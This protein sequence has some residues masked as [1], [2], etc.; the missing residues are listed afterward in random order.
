MRDLNRRIRHAMSE[1]AARGRDARRVGASRLRGVLPVHRRASGALPDHPAVRV[2]RAG[3]ASLPLR[4]RLAGLRRGAARGRSRTA[5]SA[6]LD[7]EVTA[8]ALMGLGELVGMRWILWGDGELPPRVSHELERIIRCILE[9][10]T[11]VRRVGLVA[12]ASYLPERWMTAAEIAA[13]SGIPE[14]GDRREVRPAREAHRRR[15]TSTSATWRSRRSSGCSRRPDIDPAIDRRRH[16]LRLDVAGL[17]RCG[18]SRRASPTGSARQTR[19]RSSTTT[20]RTARRSRC[21]S[22]A[23]CCAP[24]RSCRTV[25]VV[26]ACRESYLLDYAQRALALHV[27]LRRRRGRRPARRRRGAR[28]SCSA[29]TRSRTARTRCR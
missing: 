15:R 29:R 21:A 13:L 23:T 18:R 14:D 27:Q 28:T 6:T 12:T 1:G 24:S 16:V 4:A 9:A 17:R 7:P 3:D 26:A 20:S 22:R 2:R 25:L 19:S 8:Y 11:D 10:K 5:R